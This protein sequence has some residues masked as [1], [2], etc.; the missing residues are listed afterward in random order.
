MARTAPYTVWAIG[1]QDLPPIAEEPDVLA[2][3][4]CGR[5]R[6]TRLLP[7]R[8]VDQLFNR[9]IQPDRSATIIQSL[10]GYKYSLHGQ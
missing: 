3:V 7:A 2:D 1:M 8:L 6:F 9:Y 10:E 5:R 4:I